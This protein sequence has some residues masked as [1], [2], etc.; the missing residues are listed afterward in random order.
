MA[1]EEYLKSILATEAEAD[2]IEAEART[3]ADK[4]VAEANKKAQELMV[5]AEKRAQERLMGLRAHAE[6]EGRAEAE[7]LARDQEKLLHDL[8]GRYKNLHEKIVNEANLDLAAMLSLA[9]E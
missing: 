7:K 6:A 2:R 1:I 3:K 4:I 8:Q 9:K 5:Q